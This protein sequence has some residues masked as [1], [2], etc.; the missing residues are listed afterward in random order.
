MKDLIEPI[1]LIEPNNFL[2]EITNE[3]DIVIKCYSP[4]Y[5]CYVGKDIGFTS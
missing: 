2:N 5:I 1:E 4:G 3:S